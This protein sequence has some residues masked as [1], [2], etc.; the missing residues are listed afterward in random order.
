MTQL[1]PSW[2]EIPV[3]DLERAVAFYRLVFG[4]SDMPR[5][6]DGPELQ[7]VVLR[8]SKKEGRVPGVS[9]VRSPLHQPGEGAI[10]NFHLASYAALEAV[11]AQIVANGGAQRAAIVDM[12]DGVRY[13]NVR[14]CEGNPLALSAYEAPA[15]AG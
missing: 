7:I 10:I 3:L 15:E 11:V 4:L 5:Y 12:G 1:Y 14:D 8:P 9:L 6:D 13:V 2:I